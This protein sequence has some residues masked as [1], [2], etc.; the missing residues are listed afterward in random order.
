MREA[1]AAA[2][3]ETKA[4]EGGKRVWGGGGGEVRSVRGG[5]KDE[6]SASLS[7]LHRRESSGY[8]QISA[9]AASATKQA[10]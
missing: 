4:V 8:M 6:G 7:R 2:A 3:Q 1:A 9:A 10:P 5:G